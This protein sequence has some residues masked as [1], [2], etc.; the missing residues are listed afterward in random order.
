[1]RIAAGEVKPVMAWRKL[2]LLSHQ[3]QYL[4]SRHPMKTWFDR[5]RAMESDPRVLQASNYPMQCWLD[6]AEGGWATVVVVE[7]ERALAEDLADELAD[8]AW[9]IEFQKKDA[10]RSTRPGMAD[11]APG[12]CAQRYR[13][14]GTRRR[15][16]RQQSDSTILRQGIRSRAR[17]ADRAGTCTGRGRRRRVGH[18]PGRRQCDEFFQP[19]VRPVPDR[20]GKMSLRNN[21][22]EV[23]MGHRRLRRRPRTC[24]QR[25]ARRRGQP[26]DAYAPRQA[27]TTRWRC[28]RPL[29]FQ[30]FAPSRA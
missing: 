18:P 28:S 17:A 27:A 12:E 21:Q 26:A 24:W 9:S 16:R 15:C 11:P 10:F 7:R 3:E 30:Y 20:R 14:H 22:R 5:A 8:L 4:T 19:L 2:R 1:M 29:N 23:D 13:R 25:A 6:V